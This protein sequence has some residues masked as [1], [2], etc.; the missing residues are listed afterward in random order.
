MTRGCQAILQTR[1]LLT[2]DGRD[3]GHA[4]EE[5][6]VASD[7]FD[8]FGAD[9]PAAENVREKRADVVEPLRAAEGDDEHGIEGR[10]PSQ[11]SLLVV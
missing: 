10:Q 7:L 1:R 6:V 3:W 8:P 5:L 2:R 4:P 9:A 11:H